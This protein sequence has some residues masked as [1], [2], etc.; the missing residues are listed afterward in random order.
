MSK[1]EETMETERKRRE[2][3][4]GRLIVTSELEPEYGGIRLC[5]KCKMPILNSRRN[6]YCEECQEKS[7]TLD[8]LLTEEDKTTIFQKHDFLVF[9][10]RDLDMVDD[11]ERTVIKKLYEW[12]FGWCNNVRHLPSAG[13]VDTIHRF[14]CWSC[15]I[16]LRE[17]VESL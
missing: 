7:T 10:D 15:L 3:I 11:I 4:I 14:S 13:Y 2:S 17:Y 12:G 6:Y 5:G 8:F 16:E 1:I 9:N